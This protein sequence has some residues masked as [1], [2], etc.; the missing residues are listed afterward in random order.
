MTSQ[1]SDVERTLAAL[2]R[3]GGSALEA[4]DALTEH[5]LDELFAGA[6]EHGVLPL[7][8]DRLS[9]AR[10]VSGP[11]RQR[12]LIEKQRSTVVDLA[13]ERE[14]RRLLAS[15]AERRI[16]VL[17]IK[18]SQ[19]A[20]SHY[21]RSD[22]RARVDSDLLVRRERRDDAAQLLRQ[23]GYAAAEKVVGEL[24]ATQQLFTR[25]GPGDLALH[26][27]LHW[28]WSS[29]P[30][31]ANVLTFDEMYSASM[32][33]PGLG[34]AARGLSPVHALIVAC[35]HRVAHHHDEGDQLKWLYDIHLIAS[36]LT[37][38]EW[39][40]FVSLASDRAIGAVC[41][42]G[43]ERAAERLGTT[44]PSELRDAVRAGDRNEEPTAAYLEARSQADAVLADLRS[45]GWQDRLRLMREHILPGADYMR[46]RYAPDSH[47]PLVALYVLRMGRGARRWFHRRSG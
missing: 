25:P 40:T 45:L 1:S 46:R 2:L 4:H 12:S 32:P 16:D 36:R 41:V 3:E 17:V 23:L 5:D 39:E 11:I 8:A 9:G 30:A 47:L 24:N 7:I 33:I 37:P 28:R 6:T 15:F 18:G 20:Y 26:I 42:Q 13:L 38:G 22:L 34:G 43:L 14:L 35:V 44:Y 27:D 29:P 19:L 31:F 10:A 21:E